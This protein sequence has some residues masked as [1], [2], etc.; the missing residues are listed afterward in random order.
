MT[1]ASIIISDATSVFLN[2]SEFAEVAT[3]YPSGSSVGKSNVTVVR[4]DDDLEGT[5]ESH[6]DGVTLQRGSGKAVRE[7][8]KL[9]ML[10]TV[11]VDDTRNP[12]DLFKMADGTMLAVKRIL[13]RDGGMMTVLCV[14]RE[15][16]SVRKPV[17][18]G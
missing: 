5:R 4:V 16:V 15:S 14:H 17:K 10:G 12:A 18:S 8:I 13:G 3:L 9:E 1:L 11:D 7:S 6:G 2:T